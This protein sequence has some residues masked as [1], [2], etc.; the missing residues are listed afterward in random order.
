MYIRAQSDSFKPYARYFI[1]AAG[2]E[3]GARGRPKTTFR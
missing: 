3:I 2:T 1:I